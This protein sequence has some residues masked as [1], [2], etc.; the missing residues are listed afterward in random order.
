MATKRRRR[1]G[2]KPLH[3]QSTARKYKRL[4]R[5]AED[6]GFTMVEL[7]VVI[8]ILGMI[9]SGAVIS[10]ASIN[11]E[12]ALVAGTKQVEGALKRAK[13]YAYQENVPY[14][15][16]FYS[17]GESHPNSYAFWRA[18]GS[19]PE[20]KAVPAE[21]VSGGYIVV[22]NGVSVVNTVSVSFT[23]SGT[24]MTVTPGTVTLQMNGE[25]R[26]VSIDSVGKISI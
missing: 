11:K 3:A 20:N 18:G 13:T 12:N 17:G 23:P 15:I 10:W 21:G 9:L 1:E 7:I 22:N 24:A 4:G 19:Q 2:R 26:T 8:L 5:S 16:T 6:A 25:Q 14:T